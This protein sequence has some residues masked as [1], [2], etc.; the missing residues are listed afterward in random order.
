MNSV[1][2]AVHRHRGSGDRYVIR[3]GD[4]GPAARALGVIGP[5]SGDDVRAVARLGAAAFFDAHPGTVDVD[6]A[7]VD[8]Q[9]WG[10]TQTPAELRAAAGR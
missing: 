4:G 10:P 6:A 8:A 7:W 3:W 2:T 9:P 1:S 5:L